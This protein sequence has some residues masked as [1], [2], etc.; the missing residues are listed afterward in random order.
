M[1]KRRNDDEL[2][3]SGPAKRP[4][5]IEAGTPDRLSTLSNEVLLHILSFLPIPS[6]ITCQ[7]LSRR[8]HALAGDSE[9]WKRQYFS[10]W[11]RPRARRLAI[12]RRTSFPLSKTEYSPRVSTWL[13]HGHL[14]RSGRI[15]N[16][17]RQYHLK[18]NW[19]KGICRVTQIHR[20]DFGHGRRRSQKSA[21]QKIISPICIH[22][23]QPH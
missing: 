20:K 21:K 7:R 14:D 3:R 18:H 22:Q 17:K 9:L 23:H 13:D 8:F 6:L 10:K 5:T 4:H 12:S 19:S 15:T 1:P 2:S 16:W 11:V